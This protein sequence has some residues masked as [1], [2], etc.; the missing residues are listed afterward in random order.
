MNVVKSTIGGI[1]VVLEYQARDMTDMTTGE[2][3][4]GTVMRSAS[5]RGGLGVSEFSVE[6]D[7]SKGSLVFHCSQLI[8]FSPRSRFVA[9]SLH[10][11]QRTT[12]IVRG[13]GS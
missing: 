8:A 5:C 13:T 1:V 11:Q 6:R 2:I 9:S 12:G 10:Q 7:M 4:T 3:G